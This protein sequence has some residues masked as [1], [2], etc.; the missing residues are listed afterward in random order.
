MKL[1][2]TIALI[3]IIILATIVSPGQ[4]QPNLLNGVPPQGSYDGSSADTV[5]LMNGNLVLH[6]PIPVSYPQRGKLAIRYYLAINSK[7]WQAIAGTPQ[8]TTSS[9]AQPVFTSSASFAMSRTYTSVQPDGQL[10]ILSVTRPEKLITWDGA[11]HNLG[12]ENQ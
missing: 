11:S 8:W 4:T 5:N 7:S 10:P 12:T 3:S 1:I 6:V 2:K 9:I